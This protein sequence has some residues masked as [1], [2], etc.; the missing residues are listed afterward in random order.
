[1]GIDVLVSFF[2]SVAKEQG[3]WLI[4]IAALFLAIGYIILDMW[5]QSKASIADNNAKIKELSS[6]L[7]D[8]VMTNRENLEKLKSMIKG[9]RSEILLLNRNVEVLRDSHNEINGSL[10]SQQEIIYNHIEKLAKVD[11][12]L[13]AV[14]RF[15][16]APSR[17]TDSL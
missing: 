10:K 4:S 3:P 9:L 5:K 8:I 17:A 15:I 16:D 6:C 13:D 2:L 14:F 12:K 11:S 1:M 7:S